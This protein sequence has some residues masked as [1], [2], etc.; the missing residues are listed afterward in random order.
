MYNLCSI[1]WSNYVTIQRNY[2]GVTAY[3]IFLTV[4]SDPKPGRFVV[5]W[6]WKID[7]SSVFLTDIGKI[8]PGPTGALTEFKKIRIILIILSKIEK[9]SETVS[10]IMIS[11]K[12]T[13]SFS[14]ILVFLVLLHSFILGFMKI[15]NHKLSSIFFLQVRSHLNYRPPW[16]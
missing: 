5:L 4:S 13:I 12:M 9:F 10:T 1:K 11:V 3:L 2:I 7:K 6:W 15:R 14:K 16:V 8:N